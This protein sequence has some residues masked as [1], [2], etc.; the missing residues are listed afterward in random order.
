MTYDPHLAAKRD[1]AIRAVDFVESDMIVGLGTGSTAVLVV[2]EIARRLDAGGL[3]D[4]V[5]VPTSRTTEQQALL[6]GIPLASIESVPR[7]DLTIDGADEVDPDGQLIKGLGGALLREKIVATASTRMVIV[8]DESK[9]VRRLGTRSPLPVEVVTFAA[10]AH[11]PA[12]RALGGVPSLRMD[13][14]TP[15]LSDEGHY[16]LDCRFADGITDPHGLQRALRDR[17]GVVET[18]LFLD[19]HP[20]V[21]VGRAPAA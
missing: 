4:V 9:L 11:A 6:L 16:I 13:G 10:K 21:I 18:G 19:L 2:E 14:D 17:P 8:V 12:V 5:G 15:F 1:A 20:E 7:I 3:H